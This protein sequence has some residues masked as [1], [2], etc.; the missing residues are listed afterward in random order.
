MPNRSIALISDFG[1][2][3]HYVGS[4]KGV[5]LSIHPKAVIFDITHKIRPQN[6]QEAAFVL[7]SAYPYLPQG[8]IV[9]VVVDPTVGTKR[10]ALCV[11]T[12]HAYLLG[13]DNGVLS[14][15]LSDEK[16]IQCRIVTNDRY[17]RKPVSATFHGRDIFAPV[18]A[19]LSRSDIFSSLGPTVTRVHQIKIP[20]VAFGRGVIRGNVV[21]ID[22][23][24]NAMTNISRDAC[25]QFL[26]SN[27]VRINA[28]SKRGV[29][30]KRTFSEGKRGELIAFWNSS[31]HLELAV[32]ED[33]AEKRFLIRIGD[34]VHIRV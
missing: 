18:A 1:L 27:E 14:M 23:F 26:K 31:H 29:R 11:R 13:P 6:I 9:V 28:G 30:L 2:R 5:I 12:R 16:D 8:T 25:A 7:Y 32:R 33:S 20:R 21:Y 4:L 10:R 3:D 15:V 34:S 22:R 24:G 17:F 19:W